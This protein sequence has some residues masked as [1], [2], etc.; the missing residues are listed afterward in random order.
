MKTGVIGAGSWGTT[1]ANLLAMKGCDVNLW[2]YEEDLCKRMRE[3]RVNDVYLPEIALSEKIEPTNSL[4]E[5]LSE[6]E[7]VVSAVPSQLVRRVISKA[8]PFISE[9]AVIVSLSKGIE[10]GSLMLMSGLLKEILPPKLHDNLCYLSGPSFAREVA[11]M[12]PTAVVIASENREAAKKAQKLFTTSYFRVYTHDDVEGVELGGA[13]KNVIAI[14]TG[15]SDGLGFGYNTR[16]ALI[17]RGLAE[18][19]R[20]GVKLGAN[21]LTFSG[22]AGMG[23]LVLTCT[24]ELS[25]NRT[26]GFK[27]GKGMTLNE[28]TEGMRMV[29]EGITTAK[30]VYELSRKAGIDMPIAEHVYK[31]LYE[32]LP[33][34][35]AVISLMSRESK[36]ELE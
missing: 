25:R 30:V 28:A 18:I 26:I 4:E 9:K 12:M 15:I 29:A 20:L 36:K 7:M 1:I 14:A 2:V 24:G 35:D 17:T 32:G 16:A 13:V 5:A 3:N 23:D 10:D 31:I 6:V 27:I 33:A 8:V 22:L 19:A 34:K 21:P 11:L